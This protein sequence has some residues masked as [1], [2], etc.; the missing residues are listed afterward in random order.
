MRYRNCGRIT[1]LVILVSF[2]SFPV[3]GEVPTVTLNDSGSGGMRFYSDSEVR[4]IVEELSEAAEA[5]IEEA[6]ADAAKAVV[7]AALEKEAALGRETAAARAEARRWE[8]EYRESRSRGIK[9]AVI[10]GVVCFLGGIG[11]G[12]FGTMGMRN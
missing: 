3:S 9:N 8:G 5:A 6:A 10:A 12:V 1:A 4:E 11:V 2:W 7:L